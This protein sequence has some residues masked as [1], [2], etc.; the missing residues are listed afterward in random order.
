MR[1]DHEESLMKMF[2]RG[3]LITYIQPDANPAYYWYNP[4][5]DEF[6]DSFLEAVDLI[7]DTEGDKYEE[8]D[9]YSEE[10]C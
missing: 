10:G 4:N 2:P 5:K 1:E 7:V 9:G 8:S 3:F 6:L